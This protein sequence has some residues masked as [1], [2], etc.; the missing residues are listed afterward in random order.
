MHAEIKVNPC[1]K[2]GPQTYIISGPIK[3]NSQLASVI[4]SVILANIMYANGLFQGGSNPSLKSMLTLR[5]FKSHK[6]HTDTFSV[7]LSDHGALE[8]TK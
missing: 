2:N 6:S 3:F 7:I 1:K 8:V 4:I 5:L